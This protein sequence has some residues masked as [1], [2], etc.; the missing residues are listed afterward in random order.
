VFPIHGHS[1]IRFSFGVP[2]FFVQ[3]VES[4]ACRGVQSGAIVESG[5]WTRNSS[6]G[7]MSGRQCGECDGAL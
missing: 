5:C 3:L 2:E 4:V 6:G 1:S 7:K